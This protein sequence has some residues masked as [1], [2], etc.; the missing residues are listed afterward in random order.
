MSRADT[1]PR[2]FLLITA[3]HPWGSCGC[4]RSCEVTQPGQ[5]SPTDWPKGY[6]IDRALCWGKK[7]DGRDVQ[8]NVCL[9]KALL[10]VMQVSFPGDGWPSAFPCRMV[11]HFLV[12]PACMCG[13]CFTCLTTFI[14]SH[15][16]PHSYTSDSL[17][18]LT[19]GISEWM[20]VW[21]LVAGR[22]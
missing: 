12:S 5:L 10:G 21:G 15:E 2:L 9:P 11:K 3:L 16:F 7:E 18:D 17:P 20:P 1:E 4:T 6:F 8:S 19:E 22:G 13:F 14:S